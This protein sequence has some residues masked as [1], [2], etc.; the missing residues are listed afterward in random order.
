V[1]LF[2]APIICACSVFS[3]VLK[4]W[5]ADVLTSSEKAHVFSLNYT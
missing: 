2:I 1:V 4:A 3:M 5:F